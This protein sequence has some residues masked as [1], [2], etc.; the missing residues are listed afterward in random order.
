MKSPT[1]SKSIEELI[2]QKGFIRYVKK[3][4]TIVADG[5]TPNE[6]RDFFKKHGL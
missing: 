3:T 5:V 4:K 1:N 6:V 2:E